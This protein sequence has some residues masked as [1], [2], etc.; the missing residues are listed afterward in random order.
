M[1]HPTSNHVVDITNTFDRKL[2]AI[3]A[4]RSQHLEPHTIED[5]CVGSCAHEA[6]QPGCR[7]GWWR[8]SSSL[9]LADRHLEDRHGDVGDREEKQREVEPVGI[10]GHLRFAQQSNA[11]TTPTANFT[12]TWARSTSLSVFASRTPTSSTPVTS[13]VSAP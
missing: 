8:H 13:W 2:K 6:R 10:L 3:L 1:A 9:R 7:G 5:R 11:T 4:H 12:P